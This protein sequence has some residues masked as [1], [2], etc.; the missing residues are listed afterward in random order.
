M[1]PTYPK[2]KLSEVSIAAQST[3]Y[4]LLETV[5]KHIG[6]LGWKIEY[7]SQEI[8]DLDVPLYPD[9]LKD[10]V[11]ISESVYNI[12]LIT[13]HSLGFMPDSKAMLKALALLPSTASSFASITS[14][15]LKKCVALEKKLMDMG[16]PICY[17]GYHFVPADHVSIYYSGFHDFVEDCMCIDIDHNDC[18]QV[19]RFCFKM[20]E[21]YENGL[22]R[23]EAIH[24]FFCEYIS[25]F[26]EKRDESNSPGPDI[27]LSSVCIVEVW[28]TKCDPLREIVRY[29]IRQVERSLKSD[30]HTGTRDVCF[31]VV[32]SG[33]NMTIYGGVH[34][35]YITIDRLV[36]TIWLVPQPKDMVAM[37]HITRVLKAFKYAV[38]RLYSDHTSL[39]HVRQ[40]RFPELHQF[41]N[42]GDLIE[43]EYTD[44]IQPHIF[45][46]EIKL[47]GEERKVIIKFADSYGWSVHECLA[48]EGYAPTLV[49]HQ[50][51]GRFIAVVMDEVEHSVP[52]I[53][54]VCENPD[55]LHIVKQ[56]WRAILDTLRSKGFVHGDL[57]HQNILVEPSR[58][59]KVIDFDWAGNVSEAKYP[60]FMNHGEIQWPNGAEEGQPIQFEHDEHWINVFF[61][62][63][64][65][66][67]I[68]KEIQCFLTTL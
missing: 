7:G 27:N 2:E 54:Y 44:Y 5:T 51:F 49:H 43:I 42:N 8:E 66:S 55:K 59:V 15:N 63:V 37:I 56:Q 62:I 17:H 30:A 34:G 41:D 26:F 33:P 4:N 45:R 67:H 16:F 61:N 12:L 25:P 1:H 23:V 50:Q 29:Y 46:G 31:L 18:Q 24:E 28:S 53:D 10:T 52:I 38:K 40:P 64:E 14:D 58:K 68:Y 36:S 32:I 20:S 13:D 9:F 11:F 39:K 48:E 22:E 35:R 19:L 60:M 6:E 47:Q 21:M 3:F 57:R 65:S